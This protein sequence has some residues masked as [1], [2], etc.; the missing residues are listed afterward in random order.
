MSDKDDADLS[1]R[2][3][4]IHRDKE[5]K[6]LKYRLMGFAVGLV[7]LAVLAAPWMR[8]WY[9]DSSLRYTTDIYTGLGLIT[10]M[11]GKPGLEKGNGYLLALCVL[12]ALA[13]VMSSSPKLCFFSAVG[14]ALMTGL[15]LVGQPDG[16]R[17]NFTGAPGI[18]IILWVIGAFVGALAWH[19][20]R[21][22]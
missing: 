7:Q 8:F 17:E 1:I 5:F 3:Q 6:Q 15:V 10:A 12:A 22:L 13:M 19:Q 21:R 14:G 16:Y 2:K 20:D 9:S 11:Q 18:A 4:P